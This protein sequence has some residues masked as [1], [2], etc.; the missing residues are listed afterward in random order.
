MPKATG[1][2]SILPQSD[3]FFTNYNDSQFENMELPS[4]I[5]GHD[6]FGNMF[7]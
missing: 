3:K 7:K 1:S 4:M 6:P 2:M 5:E